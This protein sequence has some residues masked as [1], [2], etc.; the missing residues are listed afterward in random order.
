MFDELVL[1]D[2]YSSSIYLACARS[3]VYER[4]LR[5]LGSRF[6]DCAAVQGSKLLLHLKR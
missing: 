5:S 4:A 1:F 3:G 2:L 6:E